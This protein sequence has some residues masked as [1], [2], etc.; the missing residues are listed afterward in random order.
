M[1]TALNS[2]AIDAMLNGVTIDLISLH[3]GD[4]GVDGTANVVG[5][6]QA[7][8]FQA[9]EDNGDGKRKREL[10]AAVEFTGLTPGATVAYIGLWTNDT[11]DVFLGDITRDSGDATV[12]AAGEYNVTV[13]TKIVL[14][15]AT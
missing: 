11:P 2:T 13:A 12:N 6:A 15:N 5:A 7:A 4:P 14:G 9:A 8:T 1:A 10:D 3:S